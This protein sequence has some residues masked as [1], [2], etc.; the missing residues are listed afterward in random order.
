MRERQ[1]IRM[2]RMVNWNT[3]SYIKDWLHKETAEAC[4]FGL[5]D[6]GQSFRD[7]HSAA[8]GPKALNGPTKWPRHK[9]KIEHAPN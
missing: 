6:F 5:K 2:L 4:E 3:S 9:A 8:N 1:K 7:S